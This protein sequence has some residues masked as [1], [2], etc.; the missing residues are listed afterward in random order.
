[1][2]IKRQSDFSKKEGKKRDPKP[3]LKERKGNANKLAV[4][5]AAITAGSAK[6]GHDLTRIPVAMDIIDKMNAKTSVLFE[7]A[8]A[9]DE[10]AQ[11]FAAGWSNMNPE[12][13][14]REAISR[15]YGSPKAKKAGRKGALLMGGLMGAAA[16]GNYIQRRKQDKKYKAAK[17]KYDSDLEAWKK[18]NKK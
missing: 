2:I 13:R 10:K 16:V 17:E 12:I 1:M 14:N 11:K 5:D 9:G 18:R 4:V 6:L 7:K 15:A 8:A 3:R